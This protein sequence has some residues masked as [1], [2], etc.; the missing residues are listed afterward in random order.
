MSLVGSREKEQLAQ[1]LAAPDPTPGSVKYRTAPEVTSRYRERLVTQS[2][3]S[4]SLC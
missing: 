3:S 1:A 2:S 4:P